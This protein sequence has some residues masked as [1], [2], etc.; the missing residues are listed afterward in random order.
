VRLLQGTARKRGWAEQARALRAFL[1]VLHSRCPAG[2]RGG[3]ERV[4][5]ELIE[6]IEQ[7]DARSLHLL[8]FVFSE[9]VRRS[10]R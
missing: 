1:V 8:R 5:L 9:L 7:L 2:V 3:S 4:A 10:A 6:H